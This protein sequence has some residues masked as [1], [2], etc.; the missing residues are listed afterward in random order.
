M[1]LGESMEMPI[2]LRTWMQEGS[3]NILGH[4]VSQPSVAPKQRTPK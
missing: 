4:H 1:M 3:I 2:A